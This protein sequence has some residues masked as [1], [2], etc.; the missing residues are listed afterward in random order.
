MIRKGVDS[1]GE[2]H[3]CNGNPPVRSIFAVHTGC[4]GDFRWEGAFLGRRIR[5][6]RAR[7]DLSAKIWL[8][9]WLGGGPFW[10]GM[11]LRHFSLQVPI[12]RTRVCVGHR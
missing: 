2:S 9:S 10:F 3:H 12:R 1:P 6:P 7:V 4:S 8:Y 11:E 5:Y